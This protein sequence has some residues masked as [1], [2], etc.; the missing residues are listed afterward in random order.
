MNT[1]QSDLFG[2]IDVTQSLGGAYPLPAD[3]SEFQM[4]VVQLL[5][6]INDAQTRQT[7]LLEAA[8][9]RLNVLANQSALAQQQKAMEL[10][11]WQNENPLLTDECR[12]AMEALGKIH[13]GFLESFTEE[14]S[15]KKDE[16][17][18]NDFAFA[19]F[20]DKYGPRLIHLNSMLQ[21]L[22]HLGAQV[23]MTKRPAVPNPGN[24]Q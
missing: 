6:Q 8:V 14:L 23:K 13:S 1:S 21:F 17:L 10:Q 2:Q 18:Q 3:A 22:A 15:Q 12:D 4:R 16:M 7:Q 19:D 24:N 5:S 9:E 20:I 11:K